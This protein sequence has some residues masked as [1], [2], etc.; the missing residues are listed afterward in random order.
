VLVNIVV[1]I[2]F[3]TPTYP[4]N[5]NM[6]DPFRHV[7]YISAVTVNISSKVIHESVC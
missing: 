1:Y 4:K 7:L 5:T 6:E 3:F 2:V